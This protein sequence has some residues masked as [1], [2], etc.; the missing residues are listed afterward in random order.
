MKLKNR[1]AM[2]LVVGVSVLAAAA[3]QGTAPRSAADK[4][5]AHAEDN[6]VSVGA[7]LLSSGEVTRRSRPTWTAAAAWWKWPSI[8]KLVLPLCR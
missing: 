6:G 5:G 7:A 8:R 1:F 3:F 4:Y 2:C